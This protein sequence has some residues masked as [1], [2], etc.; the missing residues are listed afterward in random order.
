[1]LRLDASGPASDGLFCHTCL[2][3]LR[4]RATARRKALRASLDLLNETRA[5]PSAPPTPEPPKGPEEEE[6]AERAAR[7]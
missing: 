3:D 6:D 7:R 1:M 4:K 2:A 5:R